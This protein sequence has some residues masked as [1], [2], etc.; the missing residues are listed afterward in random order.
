MI[1]DSIGNSA[2]SAW[3]VAPG[4]C[5]I[6][7]SSARHARRLSQRSDTRMV[8]NGVAGGFLRTFEVHRPLSWAKRFIRSHEKNEEPTNGAVLVQESPTSRREKKLARTGGLEIRTQQT[9]DGNNN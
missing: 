9:G 7:T 3:L 4:V 6:Q 8:G 1:G 2:I 5:W